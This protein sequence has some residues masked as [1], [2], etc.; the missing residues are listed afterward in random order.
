VAILARCTGDHK[1]VEELY[2]LATTNF[3][4][5]AAA[6]FR[7]AGGWIV[8][9]P[10][11]GGTPERDE[12]YV[13]ERFFAFG[14]AASSPQWARSFIVPGQHEI[15]KRRG[16]YLQRARELIDAAA[17]DAVELAK[18]ERWK[19]LLYD[20]SL[21]LEAIVGDAFMLLGAAKIESPKGH[22][23][24]RMTVANHGSFV[25]EVKGTR[26]DQFSRR[27]LRQLAEWM[28][29]A[30]SSELAEAKGA[31]VG[32]AARDQPPADRGE[33]FDDNN[34]QY[35]K[36]KRMVLLRSVDLYWMVVLELLGRLN[37][38]SFWSEFFTTIGYFNATKY[39]DTVPPEF[40]LDASPTSAPGDTK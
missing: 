4:T 22:A 14:S 35:A 2:K 16:D 28:D 32:N 6:V 15:E 1:A 20:D 11:L 17:R 12:K 8:I 31:F 10:S 21:S 13:L 3:G 29:E 30:V 26:G 5:C 37:K 9:L 24:H 36:L 33:M 18:I 19:R 39:V 34:L 27:D 38:Q 23:D 7:I 40:R 25:L